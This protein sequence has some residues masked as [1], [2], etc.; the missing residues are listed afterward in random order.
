MCF[1]GFNICKKIALKIHHEANDNISLLPYH[2]TNVF[3]LFR[4]SLFFSDEN[5]KVFF[6]NK[7]GK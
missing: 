1:I 3:F 2:A 6:W 7:P 5:L 4:S